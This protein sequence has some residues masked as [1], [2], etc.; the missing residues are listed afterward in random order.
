MR[1]GR[2]YSQTGLYH[3][4]NRGVNKQN[5]FYDDSDREMFISLMTKYGNKYNIEF[6][7]YTLM[8]NHFHLLIKDPYTKVSS[9][10]QTLTSVYARYFNKKYDRVGHLFQDRFISEPILDDV[11]YKTVFR[12]IL[13]NPVNAGLSKKI[14]YKWSSYREYRAKSKVI[15]S[16]IPEKYFGSVDNLYRFVNEIVEAECI[17]IELRPSEKEQYKICKITKLLKSKTP[18]IPPDLPLEKIKSKV[19]LLRNAGLSIRTISRITGIMAWIVAE[20]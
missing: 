14:D 4:V 5:I 18:I 10:M 7:D 13:Q 20:A 2:I 9:F 11:Y 6:H 15:T 1:I 12:Y 16:G 8:D 3:I 17:D 19:R